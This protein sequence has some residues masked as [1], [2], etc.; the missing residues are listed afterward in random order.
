MIKVVLLGTGNVAR[1]LF[2]SFNEQQTTKIIQV[3][4]RNK[5]A[6]DYF[7]A[8]VPVEQNFQKIMQ[9]DVYIIALKDD[10]IANVAESLNIKEG[11]LVHTSGSVSIKA[12]PAKV[13]RGVLYP[14]Q[15]FSN[16]EVSKGQ[17]VPFCIE[18]EDIAD[19]KILTK[20]ALTISETALKISSSQRKF[21]HLA[22]VFAN[23]FTNHMYHLAYTICEENKV[24]F[25]ILEPLINETSLKIKT[26][27]PFEAQTGPALRGDQ[28]TIKKHLS[29]LSDSRVKEIYSLLSQSIHDTYEDKL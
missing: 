20:M 10:A 8:H 28:E 5:G 16:T 24:P 7:K 27:I 25:S 9:A 14:L 6:L 15:T 23:N 17:I 19:Y 18:A 26:Q 3:V 13:R 12:I 11:L 21:L 22:A 2:H 4:G 1:F 29:L